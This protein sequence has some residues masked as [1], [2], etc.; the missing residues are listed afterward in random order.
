MSESSRQRR[1]R[2]TIL[3]RRDILALQLKYVCAAPSMTEMLLVMFH[4]D[5]V[6]INPTSPFALLTVR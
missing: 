4:A 2:N 3:G 1:F 6:S 5:F